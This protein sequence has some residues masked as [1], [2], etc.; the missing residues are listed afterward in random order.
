MSSS[1]NSFSSSAVTLGFLAPMYR[2][3]SRSVWLLVLAYG[4]AH[5]VHAQI[6]KS[7]NTGSVGED[8]DFDLLRPVIKD[9]ANVAAVVEE[10][11]VHALG[12]CPDF[13]PSLAGL[14]DS[15]GVDERC[16]FLGVSVVALRKLVARPVP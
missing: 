5:A 10:R 2:G 9:V 13:V 8:G 12:L 4:D 6:S 16:Q 11:Q 7:Q 15:W 1:R 3:S 14:A